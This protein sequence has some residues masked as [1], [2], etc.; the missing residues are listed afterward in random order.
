MK[1][2]QLCILLFV[3]FVC[4]LSFQ[5][6]RVSNSDTFPCFSGGWKWRFYLVAMDRQ[7]G[8][9]QINPQIIGVEKKNCTKQKGICCKQSLQCWKKV[10]FACL[11]QGRGQSQSLKL[12]W[13][14]GLHALWPKILVWNIL[15]LAVGDYD[16]VHMEAIVLRSCKLDKALWRYVHLCEVFGFQAKSTIILWL[17]WLIPK[18]EQE[19]LML[20]VWERCRFT[21]LAGLK[22]FWKLSFSL[23]SVLRLL[24]KTIW[25]AE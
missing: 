3:S 7:K 6:R 24:A 12:C 1:H 2:G 20:L 5:A 19:I 15:W 25:T 11:R 21:C 14:I 9:L 8:H 13:Q 4:L 16:K 17:A 22:R 23:G 18:K 10:C